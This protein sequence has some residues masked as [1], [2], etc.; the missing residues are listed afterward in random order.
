MYSYTL[1]NLVPYMGGTFQLNR[2][3]YVT[4][5]MGVLIQLSVNSIM[6]LLSQMTCNRRIELYYNI[7]IIMEMAP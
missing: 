3:R 1:E 6:D 4:A 2:Q 7:M 5:R